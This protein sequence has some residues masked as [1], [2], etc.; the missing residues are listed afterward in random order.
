MYQLMQKLLQ[1]KPHLGTVLTTSQIT[2]VVR[3]VVGSNHIRVISQRSDVVDHNMIC[4]G[5]F[6]D[7]EAEW[8]KECSIEL[9]LYYHPLQQHMDPAHLDW[10]R[11]AFEVAE[12]LGH[13]QV[14]KDQ[15]HRRRKRIRGYVSKGKSRAEKEYLGNEDEIEAY[16]YSIAAEML[17]RLNIT[18]MDDFRMGE[19][20]VWN[21]Y[22]E[23]F[24]DDQSVLLKLR[25]NISK[26]LRRLE[27]NNEQ[28]NKDGPGS[29]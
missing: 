23:L 12:T 22:Q 14:H 15:S 17:F 29:T 11:L 16:G 27:I 2:A 3:K 20:A 6:F 21:E 24:A 7:S 13:E 25:R 26:Y 18:D 10:E 4:V 8:D 1:A 28:S 9:V 5:G 19:I